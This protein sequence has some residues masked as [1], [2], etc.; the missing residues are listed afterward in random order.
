MII[1]WYY[2]TSVPPILE[3]K[4]V[5]QFV[6][7]FIWFP[8]IYSVGANLRTN[9]DFVEALRRETSP[10]STPEVDGDFP[11]LRPPDLLWMIEGTVNPLSVAPYLRLL[12]S[13]TILHYQFFWVYS[14]ISILNYNLNGS[15]FIWFRR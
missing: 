11:C 12:R 9:L 5:Y 1:V 7:C 8:F 15:S 4:F 14:D 10:S 3:W 13:L 2:N 6:A